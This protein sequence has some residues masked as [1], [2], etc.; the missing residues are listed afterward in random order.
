M[1][2]FVSAP[3]RQR[4]RNRVHIVKHPT[5]T[6]L[7]RRNA[8]QPRIFSNGE[9]RQAQSPRRLFDC[10]HFAPLVLGFD[11][12]AIFSRMACVMIRETGKL[13]SSIAR[14]FT[15]ASMSDGTEML[16]L[17]NAVCT[18]QFLLLGSNEWQQ[19][20]EKYFKWGVRL[21]QKNT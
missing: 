13:P 7:G 10:Y 19:K 21:M 18:G 1:L 8:I 14:D 5:A 20:V 15:Q 6:H 9:R 2:K 16:V 4:R 17:T 11:S 12:R 3:D